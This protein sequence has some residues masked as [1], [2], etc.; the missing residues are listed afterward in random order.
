MNWYK[1][2][3]FGVPET[4]VSINVFPQEPIVKEVVDDIERANPGYF[5]EMGIKEIRL[6]MGGPEFGHVEYDP[7][8]PEKQKIIFLEFRNI[9]RA[10]QN[11]IGSAVGDLTALPPEAQQAAEEYIKQE[12]QRQIGSTVAHERGHIYDLYSGGHDKPF[13]GGEYAAE[14]ES[15]RMG[16]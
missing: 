16:Y 1:E 2:A 10:I 15:R 11:A 8:D 13:G 6:N 3:Q 12:I 5:K 7:Q 9:Q 14:Q 4:A